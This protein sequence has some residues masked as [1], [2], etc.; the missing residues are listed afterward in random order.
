MFRCKTVHVTLIK[1]N[2]FLVRSNKFFI[3][4]AHLII[5]AYMAMHDDRLTNEGQTRKAK[6]TAAVIKEDGRTKTT[7]KKQLRDAAQVEH[8]AEPLD[9]AVLFLNHLLKIGTDNGFVGAV[10]TISDQ[11]TKN[12]DFLFGHNFSSTQ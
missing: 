10:S 6:T 5:E 2:Y 1:K 8:V 3:R 11:P 7:A 12:P 4:A 9:E